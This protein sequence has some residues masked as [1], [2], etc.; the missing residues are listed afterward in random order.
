MTRSIVLDASV[1]IP[2]VWQEDVSAVVRRSVDRWADDGVALLVPTPFWAEIVNAL[3]RRHRR[4][5]SVVI[6]ALYELDQLTITSIEVDR[7]LLL[8]GV[9]L[10][11]RFGLTIHDAIYLALARSTGAR[12][13]TFDRELIAAAGADAVDLWDEGESESGGDRLA[14]RAASDRIPE[15]DSTWPTWPG[16]GPYLA[17]L[18]RRALLAADDANE[19]AIRRM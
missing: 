18:R 13:A 16:A 5:G 6:E 17:T 3:T 7:P 12:L 9:D 10:V 1:A 19:V 15:R 8:L 2:L 14:E 4:P 11:E